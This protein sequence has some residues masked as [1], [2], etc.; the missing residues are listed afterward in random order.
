MRL[1]ARPALPE[2][3]V[4]PKPDDIDEALVARVQSL[5]DAF[6]EACV[7]SLGLHESACPGLAYAVAD[8]AQ[9]NKAT[10]KTEVVNSNHRTYEVWEIRLHALSTYDGSITVWPL[11]MGTLDGRDELHDKIEAVRKEADERIKQL[12]DVE[13][14]KAVSS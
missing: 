3:V 10:I 5:L 8:W 1:V 2:R 11:K 13:Q 14:A 7:G 9:R 6:R 12:L 4:I